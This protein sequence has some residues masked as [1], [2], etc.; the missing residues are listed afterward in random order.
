MQRR[1]D[2]VGHFLACAPD[3]PE[4]ADVQVRVAGSNNCG[5]EG[6]GVGCRSRCLRLAAASVQRLQCRARRFRKPRAIPALALIE[7]LSDGQPCSIAQ[8][9]D[10]T[11]LTRQAV[12]KH[13][14]VLEGVGIVRSLRNGRES[15]FQLDP[16]PLRVVSD[17]AEVVSRQWDDALARLKDFV[18]K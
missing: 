5:R 4:P 16:A 7:R 10:G 3:W 13:L 18:E 11:S 6:L 1:R 2:S 8:L 15:R 9:T 17:Y 14:R 12:T